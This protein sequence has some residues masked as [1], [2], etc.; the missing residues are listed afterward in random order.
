MNTDFSFCFICVRSDNI[1]KGAFG[2]AEE[3]ETGGND[4][5][6]IM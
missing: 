3:V 5:D 2:A 6:V 4:D 1:R